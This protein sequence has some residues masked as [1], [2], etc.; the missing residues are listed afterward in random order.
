MTEM[1]AIWKLYKNSKSICVGWKSWYSLH[2]QDITQ[3]K[4]NN[5]IRQQH[6]RDD[7]TIDVIYV[8]QTVPILYVKGGRTYQLWGFCQQVTTTTTKTNS[9]QIGINCKGIYYFSQQTLRG[10]QARGAWCSSSR[11][12]LPPAL[13]PWV[14]SIFRRVAGCPQ[15]FQ[16]WKYPAKDCLVPCLFPRS[17]PGISP[18]ISPA[19]TGSRAH[20]QADHWW[21]SRISAT[22]LD[23]LR[24]PPGAEM[25]HCP[26]SEKGVNIP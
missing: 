12:P 18:I 23:Q 26:L 5:N 8:R 24:F 4:L 20:L 2:R 7:K 15:Q 11:S 10:R 1:A 13:Y 17:S 22:D 14:G 6:N 19:R 3:K 9:S 25:G 16:A 21:G